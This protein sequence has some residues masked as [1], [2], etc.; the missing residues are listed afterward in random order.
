MTR[1]VRLA[2]GLWLLCAAVTYSVTSDRQTKAAGRAFMHEQLARY[3]RGEGVVTINQGFRPSVRAIAVRSGA[4]FLVIAGT[5]AVA[6]AWA[7]RAGK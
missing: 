2:L 7:A 4:W 3:Q 5:G 1:P 6:T